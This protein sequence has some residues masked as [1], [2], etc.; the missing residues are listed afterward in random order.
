MRN[1][2][3]RFRLLFAAAVAAFMLLGAGPASAQYGYDY[4]YDGYFYD[5]DYYDD[6]WYYDYYDYDFGQD[7][8]DEYYTGEYDELEYEPN[9]GLHEEEWYDPSDWFDTNPGISYEDMDDYYD[10]ETDYDY[11]DRG[12]VYDF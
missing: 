4:G 6:D 7:W 3:V 2:L 8:R 12:E 9:E 1:F 5:D 10:D 11:D